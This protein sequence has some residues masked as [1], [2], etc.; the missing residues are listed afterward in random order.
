MSKLCFNYYNKTIEV[1]ESF[2]NKARVYNS[3]AYSE[4]LEVQ[5]AHPNYSIKIVKSSTKNKSNLIKGILKN[6]KN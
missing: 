5:K 6:L 4:L 2:A 1:S 3:K